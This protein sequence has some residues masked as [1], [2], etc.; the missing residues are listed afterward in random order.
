VVSIDG[1]PIA[2]VTVDELDI[3][4]MCI[5][6]STI[7]QGALRALEQ[8]YWDHYEHTVITSNTQHILLRVIGNKKD[9]FQVL[10]T[11]RETNPTDSLEI[12]ANVEAAIVTA[13]R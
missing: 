10:I 1:T 11:T 4:P 5:H 2:Q 6:F 3:S 13:L 7:V 9:V 12:M 8:G